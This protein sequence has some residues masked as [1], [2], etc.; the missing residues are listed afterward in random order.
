[1]STGQKVIGFGLLSWMAGITAAPILVIGAGVY[2]IEKMGFIGEKP[3]CSKCQGKGY[4]L[5]RSINIENGEEKKEKIYC[6]M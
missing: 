6:D 4:Y 1:M 3:V 5:S 2:V